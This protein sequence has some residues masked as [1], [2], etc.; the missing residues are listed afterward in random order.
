MEDAALLH[1][2]RAIDVIQGLLQP[3]TPI[4]Y[5]GLQSRF[6]LHTALPQA[7]DQPFPRSL[8]LLLSYLP[9]EDVPFATPIGPQAQGNQHHDAFATL[10][11]TLALAAILVDALLLRLHAEPDAIELDDRRDL[12][13]RLTMDLSQPGFE[14]IDPLIDGAQSHTCSQRGCPFLAELA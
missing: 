1:Q 12:A 11:V 4:T 14:L 7:L 8:L 10:P 5:N 2:G 9:I 3:F 6:Q 13:D